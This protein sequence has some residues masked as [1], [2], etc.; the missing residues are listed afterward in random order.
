MALV[1]PIAKTKAAFDATENQTFYFSVASGD[2]VV[3]NRITVVDQDTNEIAYQHA[4]DD[5]YYAYN[6]VVPAYALE[7]GKYYYYYINTFNADGTMSVNSNSVP[8]YCYTTPELVF[9]NMPETSVNT[10]NFI[11]N[12]TYTQAEGELLD[13]LICTI[14]DSAGAVYRVSDKILANEDNS[15]DFAV[16]GLTDGDYSIGVVSATVNA[17]VTTI[18]PQAF[19]VAVEKPELYARLEVTNECDKGYVTVESNLTNIEGDAGDYELE[20]I[21]GEKIYLIPRQ[22]YVQWTNYFEIPDSFTIGVWGQ[23]GENYHHKDTITGVL[24][25]YNQLYT[26]DNTR[27][28]LLYPQQNVTWSGIRLDDRFTIGI[29]G[30]I[31]EIIS[32]QHLEVL[33]F[34]NEDG[35]TIILSMI[36][37]APSEGETIKDC[38][39]LEV[40]NSSGLRVCYGRSNYVTLLQPN[41]DYYMFVQKNDNYWTLKLTR[42]TNY[43][44]EFNYNQESNIQ[45]GQSLG[46]AW[47]NSTDYPVND[48][49]Q[50]YYSD[51]DTLFPFTSCRL[52][53]GN[54]EHLHI[55]QNSKIDPTEFQSSFIT[56]RYT[57]LNCA[58]EGNLIGEVGFASEILRL[59]NEDGYIIKVNILCEIPYGETDPKHCFEIEVRDEDN[60]LWGWGRTN[61]VSLLQPSDEYALFI[62]KNGTD[63][64]LALTNK[65]ESTFS[66]N[67]GEASQNGIGQTM[68]ALQWNNNTWY[69]TGINMSTSILQYVPDA[70]FPLTKVKISNGIYDGFVVTKNV[71]VT[72]SDYLDYVDWDYDMI[73]NCNFDNNI[74]AGS[75]SNLISHLGSLKLKRKASTSNTWITLKVIDVDTDPNVSFTY[76]DPYVPHGITQQY[77]LVPITPEGVEGDYIIQEVTPKW[78]YCFITISGK[79]IPLYANVQY[80]SVTNNRQYG[81]LQPIQSQFPIVIK[82][83]KTAYLS[84]TITAK[85][86]NTNFL[87]TRAVDR[88]QIT[89]EIQDFQALMDEGKTIV[90]KDY[91]GWILLC[92]P[93]SGDTA[94]FDAN[95][96]NGIADVAFN[97]VQQGVYD[98]QDDLYN[99]GLIDIAP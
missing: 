36:R 31:G 13:Y 28:A 10:T 84:G 88:V 48:G 55:S 15:Y 41:D 78:R 76:L 2:L 97:W 40:F 64:T 90:L 67:W 38:F 4:T 11:F 29:W 54:F 75:I 30:S 82:N 65:N 91:N 18:E 5:S 74:N 46:I 6:H 79:T 26:H 35:A 99:L 16:Y 49:E 24:N 68:S 42:L 9:T 72:P 34:T 59:W 69:G 81:I 87:D 45:Y 95:F 63:W 62:Q 70:V 56:D 52:R 93:T 44:H 23:I 73:L 58:F 50:L 61:Y 89:S 7:N 98:S 92:R 8:F 27:L 57:V 19:T 96:G 85:F 47:N 1:R 33:R 14:Y 94:T 12:I 39:V 83:A 71:T 32:D 51:I 17:T 21:D 80:G 60:H 66:F 37:E 25:L 53:N 20:Y 3:K 77:A 43:T 86:L 22:R